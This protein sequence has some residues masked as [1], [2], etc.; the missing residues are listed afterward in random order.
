MS[1]II[2]SGCLLVHDVIE[3]E[4]REL[5]PE[6]C[7]IVEKGKLPEPWEREVPNEWTGEERRE[8][9]RVLDIMSLRPEVQAKFEE[10]ARIGESRQ[11]ARDRLMETYL[12]LCKKLED[13]RRTAVVVDAGG[14]KTPA[15]K[16]IFRGENVWQVLA[17]GTVSVDPRNPSGVSVLYIEES[18]PDIEKSAPAAE[19]ARNV[20]GR[21]P[22]YPWDKFYC[23]VIRLVE[24]DPDGLPKTQAELERIMLQWC[25]VAW[26]TQPGVS[27]VREKVSAIYIHCRR[28]RPET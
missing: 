19:P 5:Y 16:A 25:E 3:D 17:T 11:R 9:K 22:A 7:T 10:A 24:V 13:G 20:G 6:G 26:G 15:D 28:G 4:G 23:E 18:A 27:T 2:P 21:P 8:R 12:L 1:S 14:V